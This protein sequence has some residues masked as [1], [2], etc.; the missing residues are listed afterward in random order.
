MQLPDPGTSDSKVTFTST[1]P[2]QTTTRQLGAG[3]TTSVA[4][5]YTL[6]T[7]VTGLTSLTS[8]QLED[9]SAVAVRLS[10]DADGAGRVPPVVLENSVRPYNLTSGTP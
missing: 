8:D 9:V 3:F 4:F 6:R 2:T 7:G 10:L 1:A 5:T